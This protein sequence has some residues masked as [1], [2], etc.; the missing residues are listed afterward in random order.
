VNPEPLSGTIAGFYEPALG[1]LRSM[2]LQ[3]DSD[4]DRTNRVKQALVEIGA[5]TEPG[6][7]TPAAKASLK[8]GVPWVE[9][10]RP[11]YSR[12]QEFKAIACEAPKSADL[13][14]HGSRIERMCYY[15]MKAGAR[16]LDW[17][18]YFTAAGDVADLRPVRE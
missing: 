2:E 15:R 11:M 8:T 3:P 4:P 14:R 5:G 7:L 18:F 16:T 13:E 10:L 6:G 17:T 12:P 1:P 9:R